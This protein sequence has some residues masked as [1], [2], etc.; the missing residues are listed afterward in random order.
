MFNFNV[1]LLQQAQDNLITR[2]RGPKRINLIDAA[3]K[4][5]KIMQAEVA[6]LRADYTYKVKHNSEVISLET[7]LNDRF[8]PITR[9][10][11]IQDANYPF[12]WIYRI[13][14]ARPAVKLYRRWTSGQAFLTGQ[15][16]WYSGAVY[17]A[18]TNNT[19]KV[20]GVAVEWT[21]RPAKKAPVLRM[22]VN[23]SGAISFT[24]KVPVAV[25]FDLNE[26]K[27][28]INYYKLAGKGYQIVTF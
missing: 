26:M 21:A 27:S 15:F 12:V 4:P 24:V 19:N 23:Y 6:A 17:E 28:L 20:P 1:N 11:F 5:L 3:L 14:E 22:A 9:G 7:V 2:L 13:S 10:I 8:D 18:N 16:C 25:T